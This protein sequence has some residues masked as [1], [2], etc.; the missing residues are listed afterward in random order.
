MPLFPQ[1]FSV[2]RYCEQSGRSLMNV[3][4]LGGPGDIDPLAIVLLMG[5]GMGSRHDE[6]PK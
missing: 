2:S 5:W 6:D 3:P 1:E 4:R